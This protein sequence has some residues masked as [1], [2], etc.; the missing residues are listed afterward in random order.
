M[1]CFIKV[2]DVDTRGNVQ[3][4]LGSTRVAKD[5]VIESRAR[6]DPGGVFGAEM[7]VAVASSSQDASVQE[8]VAVLRFFT[9]P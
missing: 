7:L 1:N 3:L 5:Q 9:A 4:L 2:F 6:V 8:D